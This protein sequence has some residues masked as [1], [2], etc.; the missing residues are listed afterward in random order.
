MSNTYQ[1]VSYESLSHQIMIVPVVME[2]IVGWLTRGEKNT[3]EIREKEFGLKP[4]E[5]EVGKW[6]EN[7]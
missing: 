5:F 3:T 7:Q 1:I 2:L 4:K 6:R